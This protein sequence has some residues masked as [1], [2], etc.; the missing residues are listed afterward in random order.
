RRRRPGAVR[1][2]TAHRGR[3][4]PAPGRGR[5]MTEQTAVLESS[6]IAQ[7]CKLLRLPTV[8]GPFARL[9]E[10]AQREGRGYLGYLAG[11]LGAEAEERERRAVARRIQEAHLP[12][13][14]TL[15]EFDV[16]QAPPCSPPP[17]G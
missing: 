9:A 17:T 1:A 12:R 14:K 7:Q 11:L 5:P 8:A 13:A 10:Q 4:R 2:P 15:E 16:S 6:A 3:L